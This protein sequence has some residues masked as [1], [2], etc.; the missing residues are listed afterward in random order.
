[1]LHGSLKTPEPFPGSILAEFPEEK[2]VSG[3]LTVES[4]G[5]FKTQKIRI[6]I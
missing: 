3:K 1:L 2:T 6:Y 5:D 4:T